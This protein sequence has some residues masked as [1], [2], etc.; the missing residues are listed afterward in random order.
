[1]ERDKKPSHSTARLFKK[2]SC[3]FVRRMRKLGEAE[4]SHLESLT[5][6][7]ETLESDMLQ[8]CRQEPF[9]PPPSHPPPLT[10]DFFYFIIFIDLTLGRVSDP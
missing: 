1:M 6:R 3:L 4:F 8:L 10:T 9:P 7:G 2:K 5:M